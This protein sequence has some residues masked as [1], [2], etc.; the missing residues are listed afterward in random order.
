MVDRDTALEEERRDECRAARRAI[1]GFVQG[2]LDR[3]RHQRFRNHLFRCRECTQVYR[4]AMAAAARAGRALRTQRTERE[5]TIRRE[6]FRQRT[7][8]ATASGR[9][10][11]R[12]GLRLALLPAAFALL[13]LLVRAAG[14]EKEL[15]AHWRTGDVQLGDRLLGEGLQDVRL[16]PGDRIELERGAELLLAGA[17]EG[18]QSVATVRGEGELVVLSVPERSL[19]VEEGALQLNGPALVQTVHGV[20]EL[21]GRAVLE[22][23]ARRYRVEVLD[24][25]ASWTGPT[26]VRS[27]A[28]G[29]RV[30]SSLAED[31]LLAL[32]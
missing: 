8:E 27:L 10:R 22:V 28:V 12:F 19:R 24:G 21:E 4:E 32:R 16:L 7:I 23:D 13:I 29:T 26:G 5:Q 6:A 31:R 9:R 25:A 11:N 17:K 30:E 3:A 14:G 1:A 15:F 2:G 18:E 20:L